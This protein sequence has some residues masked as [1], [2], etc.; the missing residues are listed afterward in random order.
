MLSQRQVVS[1]FERE[2]PGDVGRQTSDVGWFVR[3]YS[4]PDVK[5]LPLG[6]ME[7]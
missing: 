4:G 2:Q 6:G 3:R 5:A 7:A 1:Q